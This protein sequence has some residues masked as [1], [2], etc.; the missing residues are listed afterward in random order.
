MLLMKWPTKLR[1]TEAFE[2]NRATKEVIPSL[3]GHS[4]HLG[5]AMTCIAKELDDFDNIGLKN[6]SDALKRSAVRAVEVLSDE[7]RWHPSQ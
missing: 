4:R 2:G 1:Y 6:L 7:R 3:H 5:V